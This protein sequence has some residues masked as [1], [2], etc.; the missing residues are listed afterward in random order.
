MTTALGTVPIQA[1]L[2]IRGC[3]NINE[4]GLAGK[5]DLTWHPDQHVVESAEQLSATGS[6]AA[7]SIPRGMVSISIPITRLSSVSYAPEA[8]DHVNVI[9][10]MMLADYDPDFQTILPN[11]P[12]VVLA[13][14]P[15]T[16]EQGPTSLTA[17]YKDGVV[18]GYGKAEVDPILGQTFY[19]M[20]SEPQRPRLVS[21]S[22]LQ[23]A[24]ILHVGDFLKDETQQEGA[25]S[26]WSSRRQTDQTAQA[27]QGNG[28]LPPVMERLL[29]KSRKAPT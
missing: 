1:D 15:M 22:L 17:Y 23:D 9:V 8:G 6:V 21:Q 24:V 19:T 5:F 7:L 11:S 3:W 27:A 29:S 14:G 16:P 20:P 28:L 10:S 2:F 4:E 12:G 13:P 25:A 18:G 26:P